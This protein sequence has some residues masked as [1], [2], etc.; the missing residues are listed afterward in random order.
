MTKS[1]EKNTYAGTPEALLN[2]LG[3]AASYPFKP[4]GAIRHIQTHISH[5]FIVP[6]YVFKIKKPVNL[7]F[8][9]FSTLEKRAYYCRQEIELNRRLCS[10]IY[11]DVVP[12]YKQENEYS[13]EAMDGSTSVAE[14]AVKMK[15]LQRDGFLHKMVQNE[16]L[17]PSHLDK[18]AEK[19]TAFYKEQNPDQKV[20]ESGRI[21]NIKVN[22]DENFDQTVPFTGKTID[23]LTFSIIKKFTNR[24]FDH[25]KP[26]FARRI[27][28]QR[29]VDGHGDLHLEHVHITP[30]QTCIYDCIEFNERLRHL[31]VAADLAFLAMD[32]DFNGLPS[33]SQYFIETMAETLQD[34]DL[35][36]IV[37]FYKCYRAYVRGKVESITSSE[38]EIPEKDREE[39]LRKAKRYFRLALK[40]AVIGSQPVV[41]ILMGPIAGGKT[42][43]AQKLSHKLSVPHISSDKIRKE[44][45]GQ[46]LKE[47]TPAPKRNELYS[48][49]M[50]EK[51]YGQL[52]DTAK[53]H[54][55]HHQSVILD[56]TFSKHK[57]RTK[58]KSALQ[59]PGVTICFI[60]ARAPENVLKQ[61]L[62]DRE[63]QD[64]VIS[65]ARLEDFEKLYQ[66]YEPPEEIDR[67]HLIR[68]DTSGTTEET[69]GELFRHLMENNL[70][71]N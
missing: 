35:L 31:D 5:V 44:Q 20:L 7:D 23:K 24:Y 57:Y 54:I 25:H 39:A 38:E 40:Y 19:L 60:E 61:R 46:P 12:I 14:Y 43:L 33:H 59:S 26:L 4:S 68:L 11:L 47:R 3:K 53:Q 21:K 42:T 36:Q 65:D 16:Q 32:L 6:P 70:A 18:V 67:K 1:V 22:T 52:F 69:L 63:H 49:Q 28:Q 15:R 48:S 30:E 62:K 29:I 17:T 10:G 41:L 37:D 55:R 71:E 58:L 8:L 27:E 50:S 34:D 66:Q 45:G 13:F 9:D 64:K 56:A 2:F 51:T